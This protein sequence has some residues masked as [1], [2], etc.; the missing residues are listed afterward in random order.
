MS[1]RID[2]EDVAVLRALRRLIPGGSARDVPAGA[3]TA[4]R[5]S[6]RKSTLGRVIDVR[7]SWPC[8]DQSGNPLGPN[9]PAERF[10]R[11]E[12]M[13]DEPGQLEQE[14]WVVQVQPLDVLERDRALP[15]VLGPSPEGQAPFIPR[16]LGFGAN[17]NPAAWWPYD[18][19]GGSVL[20]PA[21]NG[22]AGSPWWLVVESGPEAGTLQRVPI[23]IVGTAVA[24]RGRNV[25]ASIEYDP[26]WAALG[27][28]V[29]PL[30]VPP[31][32]S[33]AGRMMLTIT[34]AQPV[35]RFDADQMRVVQFS[36]LSPTFPFGSITWIPKFA[37]RL[38]NVSGFEPGTSFEFLDQTGV[39]CAVGGFYER[40]NTVAI[41][42]NAVA[43]R[44]GAGDDDR[45]LPVAFEVFS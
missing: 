4:P 27:Q 36:L 35:R 22:M 20:I 24:V 10:G 14:D 13:P 28:L 31:L 25:A 39:S 18:N 16:T 17:L 29:T 2:P 3:E 40:N 7:W 5:I 41:P 34:K 12:W 9:Y 38:Q 44:V 23:P 11:V 32:L 8:I 30:E 6:P 1:I 37:R 26:G 21:N 33:G 15:R 45:P 43:M 42:H 19:G